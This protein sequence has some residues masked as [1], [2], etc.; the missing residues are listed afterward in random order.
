[1]GPNPNGPRSVRCDRAIRYSG[2]LG[3]RETW[4]LL[5]ISWWLSF[6]C[7]DDLVVK[8]FGTMPNMDD[9]AGVFILSV[10]RYDHSICLRYIYV[11]S[12]VLSEHTLVTVLSNKGSHS[13]NDVALL[14]IEHGSN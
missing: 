4:V 6:Y 10:D 12:D 13:K 3:V 8:H 7:S 5:E 1:M 9:L 2:F 11:L 14:N